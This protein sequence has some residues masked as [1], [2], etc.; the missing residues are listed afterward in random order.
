MDALSNKDESP[1]EFLRQVTELAAKQNP[2]GLRKLGGNIVLH[3]EAMTWTVVSTGP[4]AGVR[5]GIVGEENVR[6]V[7]A[8]TEPALA[9]LLSGNDERVSAAMDEGE[10]VLEGD[11]EVFQRFLAITQ[12]QSMLSLR[13][14]G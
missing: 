10:L 4:N 6:F 14:G 2:A 5:E 3:V 9:S 13:S 8:A 1:A 11:F 12:G 7:L